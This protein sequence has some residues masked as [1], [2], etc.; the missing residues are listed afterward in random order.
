MM[1]KL[2]LLLPRLQVRTGQ[3]TGVDRHS[4]TPDTGTLPEVHSAMSEWRSGLPRLI[5]IDLSKHQLLYEGAGS[6]PASDEPRNRFV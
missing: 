1:D 2:D 4:Q 3:G 6:S 5:R